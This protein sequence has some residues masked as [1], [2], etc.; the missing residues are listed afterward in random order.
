SLTQLGYSLSR[1]GAF[2]KF[3]SKRHVTTHIPRR[4]VL[5]I[6]CFSTTGVI[7]TK[8]LTLTFDDILFIPTYLGVI[9]YIISMATG[10]KLFKRNTLSLW[11]SLSSLILCLLVVPFFR[12]Y[13]FVPLVV[14]G[15]YAVYMILNKKV[16][17]YK[18]A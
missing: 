13:I 2:P 8:A 4:M 1:D 12:L 9:V 7:V 17:A 6:V 3:F 14:L 11:A 18:G 10:V 16:F 15:I 5:F